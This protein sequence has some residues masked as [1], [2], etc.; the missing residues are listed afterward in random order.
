MVESDVDILTG[1]NIQSFD[2]KYLFARARLLKVPSFFKQGKDPTV[3]H[4]HYE[5]VFSSKQQS[6]HWDRHLL[7]GRIVLDLYEKMIRGGKKYRSYKLD[8]I[9]ELVLGDKKHDMAYE[10]IYPFHLDGPTKR[11]VVA[12]YC[13]QDS[14]LVM[15]LLLKLLV[16]T[17]AIE[18]ARVLGIQL[19]QT[20]E[21]GQTFK[22]ENLLLREARA[23]GFVGT[24]YP[25]TYDGPRRGEVCI[26]EYEAMH[27]ELNERM[28]TPEKGATP[29]D[30]IG[31]VVIEPERGFYKD[32]IATLDFASLYPSIMQ[33][34]NLSF[35]TLVF[36]RQHAENQGLTEDDYEQSPNG[37]LF[38]RSST[39]QGLL[40]IIL[41]QL[42]T[43]RKL[44]KK[45]MAE[46]TDP[47]QKDIMNGRQLALKVCANSVYGYT[48]AGFSS[49]PCKGI[50]SSVTAYGRKLIYDTKDYVEQHYA[51]CKVIYGD[52]DSVMIKFPPGTSVADAI[53]QA[54]QMEDEINPK[55]Y[56]TPVFIE[57][58]KVFC[59]YLLMKKKKYAGYKY[60]NDPN[61]GKIDA[62]GIVMVRRDNCPLAAETQAKV[63]D[64]LLREQD[65]DK[66]IVYLQDTLEDLVNGHIDTKRLVMSKELKKKWIPLEAGTLS[67]EQRARK[68][69]TKEYYATPTEAAVVARKLEARGKAPPKR[70]HRVPYL[71]VKGRQRNVCERAEDPKNVARHRI[72][73][74]YYLRQ[75][76]TKPFLRIFEEVIG[77]A[78][79]R[80]IFKGRHVVPRRRQELWGLTET[81][82]KRTRTPASTTVVRSEA[83]KAKYQSMTSFFL[84]Q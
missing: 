75:Q 58:E 69:P 32:P 11:A 43:T 35:D 80:N 3:K 14:I 61:K 59:P 56:R 65:V 37:F 74:D 8:A 36:G 28:G 54:K 62:K 45:A 79:A 39:Q 46:A 12:R 67:A 68:Y 53:Q 41:G 7:S 38:V 21:K 49:F 33:C 24:T 64:I 78:A 50:S 47:F 26:P 22:V 6:G 83:K 20:W 4:V 77:S 82:K 5:E 76:M 18:L 17:N 9:S 34:W 16:L 40:P 63:V 66:A 23:R 1:Y 60:E 31:A 2:L 10:D 51:P 81:K 44:A 55:L 13:L 73:L 42:L 84:N 48:G 29:P 72:D 30:F 15:R 27:R 71:I 25:R 70:G 52:T 19:C 57:Y